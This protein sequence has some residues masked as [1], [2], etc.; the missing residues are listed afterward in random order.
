[1]KTTLNEIRKHSPCKEGWEK[2]LREVCAKW[3][4]EQE[5]SA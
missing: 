2:L 1:M 4:A 5:K 3:E